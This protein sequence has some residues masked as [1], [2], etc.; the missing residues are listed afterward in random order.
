MVFDPENTHRRRSSMVTTDNP[1]LAKRSAKRRE[2]TACFVHHLLEK[3]R[4]ARKGNFPNLEEINEDTKADKSV[5]TNHVPTTNSR[6]LTKKQ[7]SDM[8]WGVREFSKRLGSVRLKLRVK[9]VFLLTKAH[10]EGLIGY[11]QEVVE[12][13]LSKDRE[14][15]YTVYV[16]WR[17]WG[18]DWGLCGL[19]TLKTPYKT[20]TLSTQRAS[21]PKTLQEKTV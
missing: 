4:R 2:S 19:D 12:W 5:V 3:Q 16:L 15:P 10:D 20:T 9:T 13:L 17:H 7:L 1:K 6:L 8:A 18:R 14:T 11:T 21:S